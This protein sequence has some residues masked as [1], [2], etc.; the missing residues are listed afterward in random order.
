MEIQQDGTR[1][2]IRAGSNI[3]ITGVAGFI[4]FH[5]AYYLLSKHVNVIG[6][7]N[8]NDYYDQKLKWN[9]IALLHEFYNFQFL[10]SDI[11]NVKLY[12]ML[13]ERQIDV[14][15]H[16]AAQ[17]GV[18][19]CITN[20]VS[21]IS[22]NLD[23]FFKMLNYSRERKLKFIYASSSSVYGTNPLPWVETMKVDQPLSL[24]A[25]TKISNEAIAESYTK[26][27]GMNCIGLRFFTVYGAFGRPD[28]AM[29]I[30]T[31]GIN[32]GTPIDIYNHGNMK[33]NFTFVADIIAGIDTCITKDI[34]G[35]RIYNL[36][37]DISYNID[38][39]VDVIA[40]ELGK[41]PIKNYLPM[42]VGDIK[43]SAANIDRAMTELDFVVTT[44]MVKGV[45]HF[46]KWYLKYHKE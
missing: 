8:V 35:H 27:Y 13:N 11:N 44:P 29:W 45:N 30:W 17:A 26:M 22:S 7:D 25:A 37:N 23:G 46:V 14:V 6:I 15:V 9:R 42:Q 12:E 39:V 18:R 28:M 1:K 10:K 2:S 5:L 3:L 4:G 43:D 40:K 38:A 16:L 41:N 32:E 33:R 24:Y 21:Y 31:K 34:P 20:P 36:G 19:Y